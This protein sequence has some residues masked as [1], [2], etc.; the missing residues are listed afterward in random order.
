MM[1]DDGLSFNTT[2][3]FPEKKMDSTSKIWCRGKLTATI[4]NE[5][6]RDWFEVLSTEYD[7]LNLVWDFTNSRNKNCKSHRK[8]TD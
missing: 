3:I 1:T 2:L 8:V 5:I 6:C 7:S 4:T